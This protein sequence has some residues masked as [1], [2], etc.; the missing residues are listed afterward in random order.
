MFDILNFE[1]EKEIC[2]PA[3]D[4]CT[5]MFRL[6]IILYLNK[7]L[8]NLVKVIHLLTFYEKSKKKQSY[9]SFMFIL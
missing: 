8:S 6:N 9:I 4:A 2:Y 3:V 5:Q 1:W 7:V